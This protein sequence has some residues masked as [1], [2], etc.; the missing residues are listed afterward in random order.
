MLV[1]LGEI[2]SSSVGF[3]FPIKVQ[4]PHKD[5]K[6]FYKDWYRA[7]LFHKTH[8]ECLQALVG[9]NLSAALEVK[10]GIFFHAGCSFDI[11]G[12]YWKLK[13]L[14]ESIR[15]LNVTRHFVA[16]CIM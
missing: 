7:L 13:I 10:L 12:E 15:V 5:K 11:I 16:P 6:Y 8:I 14:P 1:S 9:K 4:F 3:I 2:E